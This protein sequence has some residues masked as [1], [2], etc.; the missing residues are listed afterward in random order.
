MKFNKIFL[1]AGIVSLGLFTS[2]DDDD[3]YKTGEPATGQAVNFGSISQ[4]E[5]MQVKETSFL[6]DV[7]RQ[8]TSEA[9]DIPLEIVRNDTL[10][11]G[12]KVFNLPSSIH[13]AEGEDATSFEVS[14]PDALVG[15]YYTLEVKIPEQYAH[16][17]KVN[18][19]RRTIQ[20]DYNWI[21]YEGALIDGFL[22]GQGEVVIEHAEGFNKW[23]IYQPFKWNFAIE[24]EE[25][26][27][28]Y[29]FEY[30]PK[31]VAD[32][33]EFSVNDDG[34]VE[35]TSFKYGLYDPEGYIWGEMYED[36]Y[37]QI[38]GFRPS[39]LAASIADYDAYTGVDGDDPT[40]L[41]FVPYFYIPA[42]GGGFGLNEIDFVLY[43]DDD[44]TWLTK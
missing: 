35:W 39:E 26:G 11:G 27:G 21:Q 41:A 3:D 1:L 17:Y 2:C 14:Y 31:Y 24:P 12:A 34:S 33:L 5:T 19:L 25:E 20:R 6:V 9:V 32:L 8:D 7:Y 10:E 28:E 29:T 36:G 37:T 38:Y 16:A 15:E 13:F 23:R 44:T 4:D 22:K 30:S 18:T 43:P 42:L 40:V